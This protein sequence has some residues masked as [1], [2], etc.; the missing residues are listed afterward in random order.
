MNDLLLVHLDV[1]VAL[2]IAHLQDLP[3]GER[4]RRFELGREAYVELLA[5]KSDVLMFGGGKKGEVAQLFASLAEALAFMAFIPGGIRFG[6]RRW[7]ATDTEARCAL[8]ATP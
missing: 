6:G 3:P 5:S 1:A 7:V 4:E 8:E 2:A